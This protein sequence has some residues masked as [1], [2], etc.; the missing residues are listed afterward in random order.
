MSQLSDAIEERAELARAGGGG[1]VYDLVKDQLSTDRQRQEF[2]N[3]LDGSMSAERFVRVA[4][5]ELRRN[6]K[7]LTAS[8]ESLLGAL[9]V[10]AQLGLEP[11][12][13][14]GHL[15]LVPYKGNISLIPGYKG[16]IALAS[17]EGIAIDAH[18]VHRGDRFDYAYGLKPRLE[19]VPSDDAEEEIT[20]TWAIARAG[21]HRWMRV[22][23]KGEVDRYRAR[24]ASSQ[25][26]PW[27]T[28]YEPMAIKTAIRRLFSVVPVQAGSRFAEAIAI[29]DAGA[30]PAPIPRPI[31]NVEL[32]P[33]AEEEQI[34]DEEDLEEPIVETDAGGSDLSQ[35]LEEPG[36]PLPFDEAG[37]TQNEP[38]EPPSLEEAE[39]LTSEPTEAVEAE[40]EPLEAPWDELADLLAKPMRANTPTVELARRIRRLFELMAAVEMPRWGDGALAKVLEKREFPSELERLDRFELQMFAA[41]TWESAKEA[42]AATEEE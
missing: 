6:P 12:G 35:S 24:S 37:E 26:G 28:D 31:I 10:S 38:Y 30:L 17:R 19:H 36:T 42:I 3:A 32:P 11:G 23:T 15:Y 40:E 29:E 2:A 27:V 16:L 34:E 14:L 4:L 41:Q 20:H 7:L 13:P 8:R 22:L 25:S 9:M 33:P 21:G 18:A 1:T 39:V 5:T